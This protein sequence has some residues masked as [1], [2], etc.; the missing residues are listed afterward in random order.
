MKKIPLIPENRILNKIYVLRG[1]KVMLDHDLAELYGVQT[2]RINEQ[3]KRNIKRFPHEFMFQ[4]S[5]EERNE[6]ITICD[7]LNPLKYAKTMPFAFTEHGL[8]MLSSVLNSDRAIQVNIE[9]IKAFIRLRKMMST[10][11]NL[12][13]KIEA[14]ENK[15]DKQFRVIFEAI[16]QLLNEDEKPKHKIGF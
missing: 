7:N 5:R 6:V 1:E 8:A 3:V 13:K 4:L 15:Y 11:R 9:L 2:K 16:K 10:Q 12:Q 14:M